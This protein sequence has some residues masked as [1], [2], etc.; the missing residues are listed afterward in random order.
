MIIIS[1][2]VTGTGV[3]LVVGIGTGD[4][5]DADMNTIISNAEYEVDR[6]LN[7][8]FIPKRIIERYETPNSPSFV[9]LRKTPVTRVVNI[10]VGGTAGTWV[11][12][13]HTIIDNNTGKLILTSNAAKTQFDD[14]DEDANIVDYY[15]GK[16]EESSTETTLSAASGTG[17]GV[18]VTVG[19]TTGI[20]ANDY[21]KIEGPTEALPETTKVLSIGVGTMAADIS[22]VH[23]SGSRVVKMQVPEIAKEMTRIIAGIMAALHMVGSTYTFATS[24]SFPEHSVTKG[25]PYPHFERVLTE[26]TKK[27]D[28][29]LARFRP[30]TAVY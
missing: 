14:D 27:R 28:Y 4:I 25:V 20:S 3:R 17:S 15:Y 10:Q 30:Q 8:T 24:Y 5:N 29:I 23:Q 9:M 7:T 1:Y 2:G 22:Y 6:L 19:T 11:D 21:V 18:I 16:M 13:D 26:L 12:P